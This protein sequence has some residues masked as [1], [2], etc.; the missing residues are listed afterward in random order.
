MDTK[1]VYSNKA[2]KYARYRWDYAPDA[3]N[4]IFADSPLGIHSSAAD[5][6][7]GTGILTRQLAGRVQRVY[8]VE[9]NAEMRHQLEFEMAAVENCTVVNG[10]AEAT[11]L[12]NNSVDLVTVA[13]AIHWFDAEPARAEFRRILRPGGWLAVLRNLSTQDAVNQ[14]TSELHRAEF[15]FEGLQSAKRMEWK[16]LIYYYGNGRFRRI[17]FPFVFRQDWERF[18]GSLLSTAGMPDES[19]PRFK[20]LEQAAR[21]VFERFSENGLMEVCGETELY[22]GQV[23]GIE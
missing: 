16:P 9:P 1:Q 18:F 23:S 10:S 17:R 2:E 19:H 8:A 7:A 12:P 4:R 15:G 14:A 5:I 6:G 11:G 22:L 13:Q 3:V 20:D 21:G